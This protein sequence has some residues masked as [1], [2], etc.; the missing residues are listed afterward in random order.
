M[1]EAAQAAL[2]ASDPELNPA[3]IKTHRG[4]IAAFSKYVVKSGRLSGDLGRSLNQVER[5][6]LL[7]DY[8]GEAIDEPKVRWAVD[9]AAAFLAQVE[10]LLGSA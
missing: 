4:L 5:I 3:L 7:A 10:S 8:T 2:K 1:F 9:Q 6:R